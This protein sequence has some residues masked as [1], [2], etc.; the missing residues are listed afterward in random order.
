MKKSNITVLKIAASLSLALFVILFSA[1]ENTIHTLPKSKPPIALFAGLNTD[2]LAEFLLKEPVYGD[3]YYDDYHWGVSAGIVYGYKSNV[4]RENGTIVPISSYLKTED[5][6][7]K[8]DLPINSNTTY[9]WRSYVTDRL[10]S[11]LY[12]K[13]DLFI[14]PN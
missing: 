9:Y 12:G 10:G 14:T 4:T 7:Y 3:N 11:V 13:E 8:V 5:G 6:F 2:G 1:C